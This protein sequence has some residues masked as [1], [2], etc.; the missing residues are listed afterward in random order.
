MMR[1]GCGL[2][3]QQRCN[4]FWMMVC[5]FI[6]LPLHTQSASRWVSVYVFAISIRHHVCRR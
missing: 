3:A 6:V 1:L 4:P 2:E 5:S